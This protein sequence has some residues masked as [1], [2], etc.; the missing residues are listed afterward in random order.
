MQ[1][2]TGTD[3]GTY[4]AGSL[5][6]DALATLSGISSAKGQIDHFGLDPSND[7]LTFIPGANKELNGNLMM[8]AAD[9]SQRQVQLSSTASSGAA[10]TLQ[11]QGNHVIYHNA[12]NAGTFSLNL[13]SNASGKDQTFTT[14]RMTLAA[15]DDVDVLPSDWTNIQDATATLV[16]THAD[17]STTTSTISNGGAGLQV[18]AREGVSFTASV[19]SFTNQ[20]V[21]GKSAV[22]DWGDGTTST[23][24]VAAS[25][26]NVAVSD[27]HTYAKQG[28]FPTRITL[29]DANGPLAQATGQ[30][31]VT[32]TK[33]SLAPASVSA[34]A[35]VPFSGTVAVMTDVPSGDV[36]SDFDVQINWGDGTTSA[37]TLQATAS[38]KFD[39]R[40]S[41]TW[42]SNGTKSVTV[43]VT[44]HGSASGQGQTLNIGSNANFSGNVAQ[45][46]LPIPGS[47]PGD[48]VATIDW[49]DNTS[50]TGTLTL[51][52]DGSVILSGSHTY[53]TGNKSF[54]THF[55][56][57]GGPSASTTST[58][59]V[60]PAVGTVTGTLYNDI[61][62]NGKKDSGDEG[63]PGQVV[64]IDENNNGK[65]DSGEPSA[66]TNSSGVYTISNVPAGSVRVT[67]SVPGGFHVDAP[68]SGSYDVT[69]KAGQTLSHLDLAN[70][71]LALISGTVFVDAD[72]NGARSASEPGRTNQI[73][74]LDLNNDG[75]LQP[76]EPTAVTDS[77]GAF[78]FTVNPGSYVVRLQPFSDFTIT[79]PAGGVYDVAIGAGST[80]SGGLFG[81]KLIVTSPPSSPPPPPPP[82]SPPP[83]PPSP[84]GSSP[85]P[86]PPPAL[87]T[88]P[89]L[90]LLDALLG[91]IEAVNGNG[92]ETVTDSLFGIP[93]LLST[94]DGA[95]NLMNV[96]LFG[97][98]VTALFEL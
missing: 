59:V 5:S 86:K 44:E 9:G 90:A 10:Q 87:H 57:T 78:A 28:Y 63:I 30:V 84:G 94:Y 26:A 51:Q 83:P 46:P 89:L 60:N 6:S 62:G 91:G 54:V 16:V 35:G 36:A 72:G 97:V 18:N 48:Y 40:G 37:G 41:H 47:A 38:G 32:D 7:K 24:T 85:A 55:S 82:V 64:F 31:T 20:T 61:N 49:G 15:G 1:T 66:V 76:N 3:S 75:V 11:F 71:Q 14:G 19:A 17:G 39:V 93:L 74:F 43:T 12:G 45:V 73:V 67:E 88:P 80:N 22:I 2:I 53:A 68:A 52:A 77:A 98:N 23:G 33:F 13:S 96:T 27:T 65:L 21:T 58:A 79:T 70:T 95:G 29:S 4:G 8:N 81:E 92:T 50:S 42:A 34:F 56:L 69:L 25:G